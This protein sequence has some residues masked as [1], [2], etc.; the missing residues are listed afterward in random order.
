M[1]ADPPTDCAEYH[2]KIVAVTIASTPTMAIAH[3]V[4]LVSMTCS[5]AITA[6]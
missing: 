6:R 4:T 5:L 3:L 2:G 1:S